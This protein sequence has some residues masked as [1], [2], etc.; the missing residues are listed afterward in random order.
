MHFLTDYIQPLT[1]WLHANPHYAVLITFLI[2]LSESL[3]IIGTI[4]PGSITMTAIGILAG[5]GVMRIDLTFLAATLGAIAG[6][7]ASYTLGFYFSDNLVSIWPFKNY[8]N[9]LN[10]GKAFFARYGSTSVLIGRFVGP[11]RSIIP[12]IAGMMNMN[13]WHF[14]ITNV[15]SAIG[16]AILY[17]VPGIFIG[18]AS[19]ELSSESTTRLFVLILILLIS[20]WLLS[21]SIKWLYLHANKY[22]KIKL[23]RWWLALENHPKLYNYLKR[24]IPEQEHHHARTAALVLLECLSF[25]LALIF[26]VLII[27]GA[28]SFSCNN[29]I[30]LFFQSIHTLFFDNFFIFISLMVSPLPL[31]T[32][33]IAFSLYAL[34][35]REWR[36]LGYWLCLCLTCSVIT[37]FLNTMIELPTPTT[38]LS[39]Y[40]T[41][42]FPANN[43]IFSIALIGFL[44]LYIN[45]YFQS[46]LMNVVKFFLII[47]VMLASLAP[48]Y[49]GDNWIF[50]IISSDLIAINICLIHWIFYR[51][52]HAPHVHSQ[53]PLLV[54]CFIFILAICF[55]YQ[56]DFKKL[57]NAHIPHL[58]QYVLT[59]DVWWNQERPLLPIFS[60]N[61]IGKKT[62]LLNIQYVGPLSQLQKALEAHGW[63]KT[64]SS[65]IY[66]LLLRAGGKSSVNNLPLMAQLYLHKKPALIMTFTRQH[67]Q[68]SILRLWRSNY[69]LQHYQQPIWLG[70]ISPEIIKKR[71]QSINN[72]IQ[73]DMIK[74]LLHFQTK[75][76]QMPKRCLKSLPYPA[77]STLLLIRVPLKSSAIIPIKVNN[78]SNK[79]PHS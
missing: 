47:L 46:I 40:N 13:R 71:T 15:I 76:L 21:L 37:L 4:I 33:M 32:L 53:I 19:S 48:I 56:L 57:A 2:S 12:V 44:I 24:L 6:D 23:H 34:Y 1:L 25:F 61:T 43:L 79:K 54:A 39:R 8:P 59:D 62:G 51:R 31:L 60:T 63:K 73:N 45:K 52:K 11:M 3:A 26:I 69:H 41:L 68:T 30:Y 58:E 65:M 75:Q 66:S 74:G 70:S 35:C 5:S 64:S 55:S 72:L 7:F 77:P 14:L 28:D 38:L 20:I 16:W 50:N 67:H 29:S 49:L 17:L 36:A 42:P 9:W 22:F 78:T 27:R 10:Y 18:T